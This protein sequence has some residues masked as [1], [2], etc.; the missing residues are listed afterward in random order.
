MRDCRNT[1]ANTLAAA[2]LEADSTG[3]A[4]ETYQEVMAKG[5]EGQIK[6]YQEELR[7]KGFQSADADGK[8]NDATEAALRA[9]VEARGKLSTD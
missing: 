6:S 3:L 7:K 8:D 1:E 4:I 9:C 2:Y 5:R